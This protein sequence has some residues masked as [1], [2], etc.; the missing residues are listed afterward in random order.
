MGAGEA[1]TMW[2]I[3]AAKDKR[4]EVRTFSLLSSQWQGCVSSISRLLCPTP[5]SRLSLMLLNILQ[6]IVEST[7]AGRRCYEKCGLRVTVNQMHF[8][9]GDRFKGRRV[10]DLL[11]MEKKVES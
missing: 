3:D 2:G 1:L 4:V 9:V 10:P 5:Y 11:F 8:D 6:A 7:P